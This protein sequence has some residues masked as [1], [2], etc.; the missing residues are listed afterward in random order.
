MRTILICLAACGGASS[1]NVDASGTRDGATLDGGNLDAIALMTSNVACS[2]ARVLTQTAADGSRIET[3]TFFTLEADIH[4]DTTY[5]VE[6]C[7]EVSIV[8]GP[9]CPPGS[10]C[11]TTGDQ[12]PAG[13]VCSVSREGEFFGGSLV[14]ICGSESKSFNAAGTMTGDNGTR[15]NTVRLHR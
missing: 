6:F 2:S 13:Q 4:A 11:M 9:S 5:I 3:T 8:V 7:D 15:F 14:I 1:A 12:F 10:T